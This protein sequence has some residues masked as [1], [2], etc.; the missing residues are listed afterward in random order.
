MSYNDLK[1]P[2]LKHSSTVK[3]SSPT[4][5]EVVGHTPPQR[6]KDDSKRFS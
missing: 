4:K 6:L 2:L 1:P 3:Y 5:N